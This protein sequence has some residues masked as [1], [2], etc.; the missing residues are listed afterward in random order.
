MTF[1]ATFNTGLHADC[2]RFV[3]GI[4]DEIAIFSCYELDEINN[5]RLGKLILTE[6]REA[7]V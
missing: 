3:P 2:V 1:S 5:K 6:K 7:E 4:K